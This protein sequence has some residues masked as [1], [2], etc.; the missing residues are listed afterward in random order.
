M[1]NYNNSIEQRETFKPLCIIAYALSKTWPYSI[2]N[3]AERVI[4]FHYFTILADACDFELPHRLNDKDI[5]DI[6]DRNYSQPEILVMAEEYREK[7]MHL[8]KWQKSPARRII[9]RLIKFIARG[10][11]GQKRKRISLAKAGE[12]RGI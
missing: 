8:P 9:A 6:G 10:D 5:A 12:F 7:A 2:N 3:A 1:R 11:T 4:A